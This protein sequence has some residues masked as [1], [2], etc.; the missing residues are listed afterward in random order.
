MLVNLGKH[1][2]QS[3]LAAQQLCAVDDQE[4]AGWSEAKRPGGRVGEFLRPYAVSLRDVHLVA[5]H[6]AGDGL[7]VNVREE[8]TFHDVFSR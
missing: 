1:R 7:D 4:D 3:P 6:L 8:C 2:L 5:L